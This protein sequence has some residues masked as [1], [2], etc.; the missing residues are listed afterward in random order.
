[1]STGAIL[2][3]DGRTLR[4]TRRRTIFTLPPPDETTVRVEI[5]N[6]LV[7][8][9]QPCPGGAQLEEATIA[10]GE[11]ETGRPARRSPTATS[12]A[13]GQRWVTM[14]QFIDDIARHLDDT[15]RATWHVLYRHADAATSTVEV[16]IATMAEKVGRSTRSVMRAIDQL[17]SYGLLERLHRGRR[18][19]G[20]SRYRLATRPADSLDKVRHMA[21]TRSSE[22]KPRRQRDTGDTMSDQK[23]DRYGKFSNVTPV[24]P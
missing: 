19:T 13:V 15:E 8:M 9:F 4:P 14:N 21:A 22:R 12:K 10:A 20:P 2:L 6:N 24:T 5:E 11:A 17:V 7:R 1:M 18:Q 3:A 16:G 23:R